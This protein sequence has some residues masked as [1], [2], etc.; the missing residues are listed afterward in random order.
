M[1]RPQRSGI[2]G[3][4]DRQSLCLVRNAATSVLGSRPASEAGTFR[5]PG[6]VTVSSSSRSSASSAVTITP[7]R[8]WMPLED[9]RPPP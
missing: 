3:G 1:A 7:G 6:S 5:L 4:G 9:Q 8:Q 2:R